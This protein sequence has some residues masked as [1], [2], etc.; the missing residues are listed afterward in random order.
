LGRRIADQSKKGNP[1]NDSGFEDHALELIYLLPLIIEYNNGIEN[2]FQHL[3]NLDSKYINGSIF[4]NNHSFQ[5]YFEDQTGGRLKNV[6]NAML[7]GEI[8]A[9]LRNPLMKARESSYSCI[10]EIFQ[11]EFQTIHNSSFNPHAAPV[12]SVL[13]KYP[14]LV[15]GSARFSDPNP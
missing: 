9:Q 8:I 15:R 3:A 5:T 4:E 13:L 1:F 11:R 10:S 2:G 6:K 7:I 14:R 12:R